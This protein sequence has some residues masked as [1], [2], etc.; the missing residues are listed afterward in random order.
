[1]NAS[2]AE[3]PGSDSLRLT[4]IPPSPVSARTEVDIRIAWLGG[5]GEADAPLKLSLHAAAESS[6]D[7]VRTWNYPSGLASGSLVR[8]RLPGSTLLGCDSLV[9]T[10]ELGGRTVRRSLPIEVLDIET[11]S[12]N[13]LDGA[14]CGLYHWSETEGRLWNAE[15]KTFEEEDWRT[16]VRG[17]KELGMN[18]IVFQEC[19]RNE[20][21]VNRHRI[22]EEGYHGLAFYPSKL[23]PGRMDIQSPDPMEIILDEADKAGMSVFMSVGMYAWFDFTDGSL[24][25][26]KD[27]ANELW[28]RYGHHESFYGWYVSEEVH[29][30]LGETEADRDDLLRFFEEFSA[31]CRE[32]SPEKPVMLAPNCHW[33]SSELDRYRILLSHLDILCP[34]GFHRMPD[35]DQSGE[36]AAETLQ[37]LCDEAGAHLW[38][39]MEAFLFKPD[40]ALYPRPVEQIVDDFRRFPNFEKVI[41]YQFPGIFTPPWARKKPGGEETVK[42]FNDYLDYLRAIEREQ[43]GSGRLLASNP[44]KGEE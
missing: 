4:M 27:V 1:M 31:H 30:I 11:R 19:F 10:A 25:W 40:M 42:L 15:L 20:M 34:F 21:Y 16:L 22:P 29:G 39:D 41:C 17:Q 18:L 24:Q 38:L 2:S 14:F 36:A 37:R 3:R 12:T 6:E 35:G 44:A 26:H 9:V 13:R 23:F 32:L 28:E 33:I 7:H 43:S 8:L 5:G